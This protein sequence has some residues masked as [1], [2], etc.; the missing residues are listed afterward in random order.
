M[1]DNVHARCLVDWFVAHIPQP[2][3][4]TFFV[5]ADYDGQF[6]TTRQLLH[7]VL[8]PVIRTLHLSLWSFNFNALMHNKQPPPYS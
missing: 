3:V 2:D 6:D 7:S 4:H 5:Q 8:G 1:R